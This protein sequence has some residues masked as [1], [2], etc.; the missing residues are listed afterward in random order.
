MLYYFTNMVQAVKRFLV[1]CFNSYKDACRK[2]SDRYYWQKYRVF[3]YLVCHRIFS[4]TR[5]PDPILQLPVLR[6]Y[7]LLFTQPHCSSS[8]FLLFHIILVIILIHVRMIIFRRLSGSTA[9]A[10]SRISPLS[11]T[12]SYLFLK[13]Y[14]KMDLNF[15]SRFR[16][17]YYYANFT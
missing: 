2:N 4:P 16:Q 3:I 13:N 12:A 8:H 15:W 17:I 14:S 5:F 9:S 7:V 1:W 11:A 6:L 10:A